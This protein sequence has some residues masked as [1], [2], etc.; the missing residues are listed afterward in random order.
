MTQGLLKM[1]FY[2]NPDLKDKAGLF[3]SSF[4][5]VGEVN[6]KVNSIYF[7]KN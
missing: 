5:L 4:F 3:K 2:F 7:K 1:P 6:M